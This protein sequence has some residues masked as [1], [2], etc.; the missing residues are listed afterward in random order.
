MKFNEPYYLAGYDI[1][2]GVQNKFDIYP[3]VWES[4][5]VSTNKFRK[6][7]YIKDD[8]NQYIPATRQ[9]GNITEY[10]FAGDGV[11]NVD[12]IKALVS[13]IMSDD[14]GPYYIKTGLDSYTHLYDINEDNEL[15][16]SDINA[17]INYILNHNS[18]TDTGNITSGMTVA[19]C[20]EWLIEV[21]N[22]KYGK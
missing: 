8:D 3:I 16:L 2:T 4:N 21:I 7:L 12:E 19:V 15:S 13:G 1:S 11:V 6:P 17:V 5:E 14:I 18:I 20:A 22:A 10:A 9:T